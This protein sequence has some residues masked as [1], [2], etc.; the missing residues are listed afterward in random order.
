[1]CEYVYCRGCKWRNKSGIL[2]WAY[3]CRTSFGVGHQKVAPLVGELLKCG[4]TNV[5]SLDFLK[6]SDGG[7][8][9]IMFLQ[10]DVS[11]RKVKGC[12]IRP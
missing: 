2:V 8:Q 7:I 4:G 3:N 5:Q 1:M 6:Q 9:C 12:V 11:M 10:H